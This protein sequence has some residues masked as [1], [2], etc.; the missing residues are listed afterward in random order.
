MK[1]I[2]NDIIGKEFGN[3]IVLSYSH[4]IKNNNYNGFTHYYNCKCKLCGNEFIAERRYI[5][6]KRIK[7][8][9][10]LYNHLNEERYN[11]QGCL[12]KIVEYNSNK[13]IIVEFQDE[14]KFKTNTSYKNFKEGIVR[15]KYFKCIFN[16]GCIGDSISKINGIHKNSY[17]MWYNMMFRCYNKKAQEK[18]KNYKPCYVCDEWL[19]YE[20]F[21]KWYNENY[22]EVDNEVMSLD[23]DILIHN[24][25]IYSPNTCLIIPQK[26]NSIFIKAKSTRGEYPIGVYKYEKYKKKKFIAYS[27]KNNKRYFLGYYKTPEEAFQAYKEFKEDYIKEIANEYKNRIPEKVYNALINYEVLY[28]D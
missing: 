1:D 9:G 21:E 4:K 25:I 2:E 27:N 18:N 13:S 7:S 15:N 22:Y 26:I 28:T 19:C 10:C 5:K 14:Y 11:N 12:M 8:C 3:A 6:S 16:I 17:R 23:K 24:N 20:N